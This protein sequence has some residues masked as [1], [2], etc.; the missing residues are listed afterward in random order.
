M[1]GPYDLSG[2][3]KVMYEP[4]H[5][6]PI[7]LI[8]TIIKYAYQLFDEESF[9]KIFKPP[10]DSVAKHM[11]NGDYKLRKIIIAEIP[12][13]MVQDALFSDTKRP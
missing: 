10:Y 5:T 9:Y 12:V 3:E 7:Y 13:D 8:F 11:Y 2:V 6:A 1:S 4:I